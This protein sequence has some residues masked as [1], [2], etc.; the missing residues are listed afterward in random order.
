MRKSVVAVGMGVGPADDSAPG[1]VWAGQAAPAYRFVAQPVHPFGAVEAR[2]L[3]FLSFAI[4]SLRRFP[5]KAVWL[6]AAFALTGVAPAFAG[7]WSPQAM[8]DVALVVIVAIGFLAIA[9]AMRGRKL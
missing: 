9:G 2:V 3:Q 8:P 1:G 5:M 7:S 6:A 4:L